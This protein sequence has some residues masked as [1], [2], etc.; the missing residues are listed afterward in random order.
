M[1]YSLKKLKLTDNEIETFKF[2]YLLLE[3][4]T[5]ITITVTY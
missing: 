3:F 2:R 5:L 1:R 4:V